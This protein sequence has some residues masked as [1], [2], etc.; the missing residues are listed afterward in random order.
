MSKKFNQ[1][2]AMMAIT[3]AS[4]RSIFRSPSAVVFSLVFPLVFIVVFGGL[5]GGSFRLDLVVSAQTDTQSVI[6]QVINNI[7]QF[8]LIQETNENK[9]E[10]MKKL[11]EGRYDAM[12]SVSKDGKNSSKEII[13]ITPSAA[14]GQNT[15]FVKSTIQSV[16]YGFNSA[17][18]EKIQAHIPDNMKE[19]ISSNIVSAEIKEAPAIE[20][21]K[22]QSIDF[23]LPGQLGF[24]ILSAGVFGT[25]FVFF[26][27]R[28]T[29]VIKR[30]FATPV[31]RPFIIMGEAISRLL[32][33]GIG[34]VVIIAIGYFA[35]DFTLVHGFYTV[36]QMLSLALLGL[37][38][39]MGFGFIISGIAKNESVIP[40]LANIITLPQFLLAG[41]FFGIDAFPKWLQYI[42]NALP[43]TY[44]NDAM[45]Q[46]AFEGAT[47][48]AVKK[49]VLILICWGIGVY[50][51]ASKTF[52]W[53]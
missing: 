18:L 24:S 13:T 15:A 49:Q 47:L 1:F 3:K 39:F 46:I 50:A 22:Y 51:V 45:R 44:F 11:K 27:L 14:A 23:I 32:F 26:N 12:L 19:Q 53:E 34:T 36:I 38:V 29:L 35:F 21:R 8:R 33:Q 41:T 4:L 52:K 28:Q 40:P 20:G 9:D 16:V 31:K 43:L 48:F 17:A 42:A 25:A 30:F 6:Y 37:I 5:G 10:L 2:R 7:P